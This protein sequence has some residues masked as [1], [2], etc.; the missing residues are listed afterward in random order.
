MLTRRVFLHSTL[1]AG[2]VPG[3]AW[4]AAGP[5][6]RKIPSSGEVVPVIGLGTSRTFDVGA[7]SA[8]RDAL[9]PLMREFFA[10][11]GTVIDSSPMYRSAESV[12]GYLLDQLQPSP[13]AF[14]TT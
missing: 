10:R 14:V 2:L 7:D 4:P 9:L 8:A 3:L 12:T 11:G 5:S 1:A 6:T 13:G